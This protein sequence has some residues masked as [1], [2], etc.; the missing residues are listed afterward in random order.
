[1]LGTSVL[2]RVS[3]PLADVLA[4]GSG[5]DGSC[6]WLEDAN[7]FV[8]S[9]DA[10]RSW[11]RYHHLFA[12]LLRWNF[13][14]AIPRGRPAASKGRAVVREAGYPVDAI[15]HAQA[16]KDWPRAARLLAGTSPVCASMAR[17]AT[18]HALLATP[19]RPRPLWRMQS[20]R[21]CS[22][23]TACSA[24]RSRAGAYLAA[25]E[26]AAGTRTP[27]RRWHPDLERGRHQAR[28]G[29]PAR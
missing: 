18:V 24:A 27:D 12:D 20:W 10:G 8:T 28:A 13:G 15:R 3:G 21:S 23:R 19:S 6:N 25:A 22:R 11:F 14:V 9:L 2:E 16:A 26:K 17:Q 1:M 5:S 7:A 4:G 29:A